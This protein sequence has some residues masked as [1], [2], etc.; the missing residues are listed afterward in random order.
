MKSPPGQQ[1]GTVSGSFPGALIEA[2]HPGS[3]P[4]SA[5]RVVQVVPVLGGRRCEL[6]GRHV[7]RH[8]LDDR[9]QLGVDETLARVA[10][11][12]DVEDAEDAAVVVEAGGMGDQ[13]SGGAVRPSASE[14][15]S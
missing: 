15:A 13:P 11:L 3:E 7:G 6:L 9:H 5:H 10:R 4:A 8:P 1:T 14:T 2:G 12:P